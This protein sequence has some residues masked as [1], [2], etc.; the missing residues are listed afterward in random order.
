MKDAR[1][2]LHEVE[3]MLEIQQTK[4]TSDQEKLDKLVA[5]LAGLNLEDY[6]KRKK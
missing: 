6:V 2:I 4:L 5:L 1:A 3:T